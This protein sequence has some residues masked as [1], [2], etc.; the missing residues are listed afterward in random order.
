[1]SIDGI[2][3]MTPSTEHPA[4]RPQ[5]TS[6]EEAARQFEE[7]LVR[8]FVGEMTKGLFN[9]GLAGD[10]SPGW[11]DS[12]RDTQRDVMEDVLTK[13]LVESNAL[14]LSD[15]LIRQWNHFDADPATQKIDSAGLHR[16]HS[17]GLE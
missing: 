6:I 15:F 13:H 16:T 8:Q 7:I 10:D 1:M 9:K 12:N 2:H 11:M 5:A 14:R 17:T 4:G 3:N